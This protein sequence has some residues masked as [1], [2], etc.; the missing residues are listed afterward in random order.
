MLSSADSAS[1]NVP[2]SLLADPEFRRDFVA[3]PVKTLAAHGIRVNE[4]DLPAEVRLPGLDELAE[5]SANPGTG[6]DSSNGNGNPKPTLPDPPG[7]WIPY[8]SIFL[9]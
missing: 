6:D 9:S 2:V 7:D 8:W 1:Q 4:C 5:I 3:D